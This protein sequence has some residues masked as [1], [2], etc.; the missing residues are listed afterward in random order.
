MNPNIK[1]VVVPKPP[2]HKLTPSQRFMFLCVLALYVTMFLQC[3]FF[4]H[5]ESMRTEAAVGWLCATI[6]LAALWR[7]YVKFK[8]VYADF[9]IAAHILNQTGL[10]KAIEATKPRGPNA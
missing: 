3:A 2:A 1:T 9:F 4:P 6:V 5:A 7:L 10:L 8:M